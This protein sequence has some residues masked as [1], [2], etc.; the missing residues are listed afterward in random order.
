MEPVPTVTAARSVGTV[1]VLVMLRLHY[2]G[3]AAATRFGRSQSGIP[4][5]RDIGVGRHPFAVRIHC[6][7][8]PGR[9]RA[10]AGVQAAAGAQADGVTGIR[11]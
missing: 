3:S 9:G 10:A 1:T 11:R 8:D 5:G 2:A 4:D 7:S 6:V